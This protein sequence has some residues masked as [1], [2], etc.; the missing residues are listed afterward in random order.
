MVKWNK[1]RS[2]YKS[3]NLDIGK[4]ENTYGSPF[5]ISESE[6][7]YS[8]NL[9]SDAFPALKVRPGMDKISTGLGIVS[10]IGERN[11]STI[12]VQDNGVITEAEQTTA[13]AMTDE[14]G[15]DIVINSTTQYVAYCSATK[16]YLGRMGTDGTSWSEVDLG[17]ASATP[18]NVKLYIDSTTIHYCFIGHDGTNDQI[19]TATSTL[20][21]ASFTETKQT[22]TNYAKYDLD[23]IFDNDILYYTWGAVSTASKRQIW[24]AKMDK[25]GTGW[26]ASENTTSAYHKYSPKQVTDG[27]KVYYSWSETDG[28]YRQIW[29][30]VQLIN[31]TGWAATKKTTTLSNKWNSE[32]ILSSAV[33]Y[34]LYQEQQSPN[35]FQLIHA[36]MVVAGTGWT[37]TQLTTNEYQNSSYANATM[38][39]DTVLYYA[40]T[41]ATDVFEYALMLGK[42]ALDGTAF[43]NITATRNTSTDYNNLTGTV[44]SNV[45]YMVY[46][47]SADEVLKS[48]SATTTTPAW[49]R[50]LTASTW[51]T[52]QGSLA[53]GRGRI[54]DFNTGTTTY[55]ILMNGY[56]RYAWDGTTVTDMT[57]APYANKFASH[58]GRIYA[59]VEKKLY[60]SALNLINDWSTVNDAGAITVTDAKGDITAITAYDG[61][62]ILWTKEDMYILYG[63]G[64]DDFELRKVNGGV[65]CV[66]D[67]SVDSVHG[68]LYWAWYDGIYAWGGENAVKISDKIEGYFNGMYDRWNV[69]I[70]CQ[71][72]KDFL[73]VSIP[74]KAGTYSE[75]LNELTFLYDTRTKTWYPDANKFR[76]YTTKVNELY[77]FDYSGQ[78]W[79]MRETTADETVAI[80]WS[81]I[82][83]P[84]IKNNMKKQKTLNDMWLVFDL[85]TASTLTLSISDSVDG[86]DWDA[87]KTFT[88]STDEQMTRAQVP[89]NYG[90]KEDFFRI[91][92]NGTGPCTIFGLEQHFRIG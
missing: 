79:Q 30:G 6:S 52:I 5:T 36:T 65:G 11:N 84:I 37:T 86:A 88:A 25:D 64:P 12:M 45:I 70:A 33:L 69:E 73:Y 14:R 31:F 78:M 35:R 27:T 72:Y 51:V 15:M 55:S 68:L 62:I 87:V 92:L 82:S 54:K 53:F 7:R 91:K 18:W 44:A 49:K 58:D 19:Y 9:C 16:L 89:Y 61:N 28:T 46:E 71:K 21:G 32:L 50:W 23:M 1:V 81:W 63:T 57:E 83:G 43:T 67:W 22:A 48:V 24:T 41:S 56:D 34:Y 17:T 75:I 74:Y 85:P 40:W 2:K 38:F 47:D 29:T 26:S 42:S 66:S 3:V 10:A 77:S 90:Q 39:I 20:A 59:T 80:T 60:F 13:D 4:G 8:R 76:G